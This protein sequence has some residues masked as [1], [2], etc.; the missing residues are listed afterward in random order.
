MAR[1]GWIPPPEVDDDL[2]R[3]MSLPL[4]DVPNLEEVDAMV[5]ALTRILRTPSGTM[6]LRRAQAW[7]LYEMVET[8]GLLGGLRVSGGKTLVSLLAPTVLG[9]KRP[10]IVVPAALRE[11]TERAVRTLAVHW[12]IRPYLKIGT[13]HEL[14]TKNALATI[15]AARPD[16]IVFDEIQALKD[17]DAGR[18]RAMNAFMREFPE[19][20]IVGLTGTLAG[21]SVED[22]AHAAGWA[23]KR[24]S[25][26]PLHWF[27]IKQWG[28]VLSSSRL[29][30]SPDGDE[31][32][33]TPEVGA[34][35]RLVRPEGDAEDPP[36]QKQVA[37]AFGDR[38]VRTPG[39]VTWQE[40]ECEV[41]IIARRL[42][43]EPPSTVA[44]AMSAMRETWE[45]PDGQQFEHAIELWTHLRQM[46]L[47]FCYVWDPP[48]PKPWRE[49]RKLW[50]D[51]LR[52]ILSD[53]R[54]E[55]F[56]PSAVVEAIDAGHYPD[57]AESLER[58]RRIEP[59][60]KPKTHALWLDAHAIDWAK[61]W[62]K[63][64]KSPAL[65]W[66]EHA[67][68]ARA[69]SVATGLP[70]YGEEARDAR[71]QR[72]LLDHPRDQHAIVSRFSCSAG[73]DLEWSHRNLLL[74]APTNATQ[75]EQ[76]LGRTHRS[77]QRADEIFVDY[78]IGCEEYDRALDDCIADAQFVRDAQKMDQKILEIDWA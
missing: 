9:A 41:P 15:R 56:I 55:L 65:I 34:L 64:A 58:W 48:A 30:Y 69:L 21:R 63:A 17:L 5:A 28:Q 6:T 19:T 35:A 72:S 16:L 23:L 62:I 13:Y 26:L 33:S 7:A 18:T 50:N 32:T 53:N 74:C 27:V 49:A 31:I 67:I 47:G 12:Q 61:D 52:A 2:L 68:F 70:Y 3:V 14:S 39:I 44:R 10:L 77:E 57:A 29:R 36:S 11:K 71:T 1:S 4:R 51:D 46:A 45:T 76:L 25:P 66:T 75:I 73:F 8:R 37:Q 24:G 59:T 22:Y 40:R 20:P 54:R 38:F 78:F 60:F 43:V 42:R